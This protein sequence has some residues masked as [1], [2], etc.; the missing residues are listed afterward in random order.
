[1]GDHSVGL[2]GLSANCQLEGENPRQVAV[3][4][5]AATAVAFSIAC[6]QPQASVGTLELSTATNG[7]NPDPNGYA[8]TID[9]GDAQ[10]IGVSATE[11]V[12]NLAAGAHTVT[13]AEASANCTIEGESSRSFTVPSG[14]TVSVAYTITC[15]AST[16]SLSVTTVTA[17]SPAD[18]DGY[19]VRVDDGAPRTLG[20]GATVTIGELAPGAHTVLLGDLEANCTVQ[21]NPLEVTVAAAQTVS[22]TFNVTCT[23]TTGSLTVTITG[24][25]DGTAA[26]VTVVSPNNFSQGVTETET[27]SDLQPGL[28]EVT[29]DEVTS[30]GTTYSATPPNR[31]VTVA[32][33]ATATATVSYGRPAAPSLNLL[34][35][36]LHLTQSTQTPEGDVPLV[37]GR[38][39]YLRVFVLSNE[40][41]SATPEVRVRVY[42]RG[43]LRSTLRVP[44]RGSSAPTSKDES[45]LGSSWNVRIP[46]SLVG[47]GLSVLADVDPENT[48]A[49]RNEAD[50]DFPASGTPQAV[51]VRTAPALGVRFVPVRQRANDLQGDVSAA[52]KSRFLESA[53]RMFP[54]PGSESD[55]HAVYTTTTSDPLQADDGNG[56]WFTVLNEIDAL[57]VAEGT[58]RNYYG[59][60]RIGYPSGLSGMGYLGLPT[61]IG[62][63][64]ELD[65]SRVMAHELGHNWDREHSPCGNPGGVDSR[66]PYPGGLIGVYGLDVPSEELKAPSVPDIMGYC[67]DPWISDYTYRAVLDYRG[68][69]SAASAMAAREQLCLLVWGR[70]VDG[71][72][73]LE[74]AFEVVTRP[75]LPKE[76]GPYSVEGLTDD[77]ARLF[78]FTF[79]A[80]E[81]ADDPR[82]T[83]HFA[84]AVPL[85]QGDA[86]RLGSL[87]L[88]APGAQAAAVRPRVAQPSGAAAPDSIVARRIAGGVAL[89]WNASAHPMIMV[90]DAATG[91]VLSFARGGTAQVATGSGEVD[92]V[93]SDRVRSR[94]M[95]VAR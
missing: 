8:F 11:S 90:R 74:P 58:S 3:T 25:P 79:D 19:T 64:D 7:P 72:P 35:D 73:V 9:G 94:H 16:G 46:G 76:T 36:G 61:A 41:S 59:V 89:Q 86:A 91:E 67:R 85:S 31:T 33:G 88:T 10:P 81:V 28:Y 2:T 20:P 13:L 87:R 30:G 5:A 37:D 45:R 83:R 75:T 56:A 66:Y 1:P 65:R 29:V 49:E 70:I 55:V 14:G 78:G 23:A 32:A 24:L 26:A 95:R 38:D 54:L 39:A 6:E 82:R 22:A 47:P 40:A 77:G 53:R 43:D 44:A 52:N 12:A 92:L 4:A 15:A 27:L 18:P 69:G 63:D 80:A 48:I 42:V 62:Y 21:E 93:V 50:N 60:V 34:I 84:F 51:V 71:R 57:R 68:A 17:G